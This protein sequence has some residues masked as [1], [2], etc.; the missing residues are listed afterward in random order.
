MPSLSP[1]RAPKKPNGLGP[2][3]PSPLFFCVLLVV[4]VAAVAAFLAGNS[5][6]ADSNL[7]YKLI[8]GGI[9][10]AVG[11][12]VVAVLWFAWHRRT[13]KRLGVGPASGEAPDQPAQREVTA[14]DHEV[15]EFMET[16]TDAVQD[17]DDRL[18]EQEERPKDG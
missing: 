15:Q 2:P 6:V 16:T 3:G 17:L 9:V 12:A 4:A 18:R 14:R 8:V 13:V 5:E 1:P 7:I 10:L 11:Y